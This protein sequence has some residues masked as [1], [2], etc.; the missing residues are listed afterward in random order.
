MQE[1]GPS[2]TKPQLLLLL[3]VEW[4]PHLG[5]RVVRAREVGLVTLLE[6]L[7]RA[8]GEVLVVVEDAACAVVSHV[9]VF[10]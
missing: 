1:G 6:A 2:R 9:D 10:G 8:L 7:A 4:A 5:V 3:H